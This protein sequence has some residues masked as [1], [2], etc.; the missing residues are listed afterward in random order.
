MTGLWNDE[1]TQLISDNPLHYRVSERA[2]EW[3]SRRGLG[4]TGESGG[5]ASLLH[6]LVQSVSHFVHF[7][8]NR[9]GR[10]K[11]L[12]LSRSL[13]LIFFSLSPSLW[14]TLTYIHM[15]PYTHKLKYTLTVCTVIIRWWIMRQPENP[16][17]T[18]IQ[19]TW[20]PSLEIWSDLSDYWKSGQSHFL[21][22]LQ[23][24]GM[25]TLTVSVI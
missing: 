17:E 9:T 20:K 2:G 18:K 15:Q 21:L 13:S 1:W 6:W 24:W 23:Q 19:Y 25:Q 22:E 7:Y 14:H 10:E 12:S 4:F 16:N 5:E 8:C 11:S 3:S